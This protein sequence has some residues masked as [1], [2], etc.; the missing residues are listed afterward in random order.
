MSPFSRDGG[1][2]DW[3]SQSHHVGGV[4]RM[5]A[6]RCDVDY[7]TRRLSQADVESDRRR[8]GGSDR[9][10]LSIYRKDEEEEEE[11]HLLRS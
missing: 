3:D 4:V 5:V 6:R 10:Q 9:R 1:K 11:V 8:S 2:P 7:P